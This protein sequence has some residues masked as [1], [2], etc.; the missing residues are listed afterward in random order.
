VAKV[1]SDQ[2]TELIENTDGVE[3]KLILN[4]IYKKAYDTIKN[5][6][7]EKGARTTLKKD[8]QD[9]TLSDNL[10]MDDLLKLC[11]QMLRTR[12]EQSI[13]VLCQ[14]TWAVST[15]QRSDE[16]RL[17]NLADLVAPS[18]IRCVGK[19]CFLHLVSHS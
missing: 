2:F 14:V 12:G 17:T 11:D 19:S 15:L 13:R 8:P 5:T 7:A 10:T 18:V 1:Y 4:P 16:G 6:L 9:G 3:N